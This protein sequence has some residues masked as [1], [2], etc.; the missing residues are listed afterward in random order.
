MSVSC[1]PLLTPSV[2]LCAQ[3]KEL[4]PLLRFLPPI[5]NLVS[6]ISQVAPLPQTLLA[7]HPHPQIGCKVK[8]N[9]NFAEFID[10]VHLIGIRIQIY[11]PSFHAG[12]T[13]RV[14]PSS[15]IRNPRL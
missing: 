2:P 14:T 15:T 8:G 7:S 1:S 4:E 9:L 5:P 13:A 10:L 3:E 11:K 6:L 12:P